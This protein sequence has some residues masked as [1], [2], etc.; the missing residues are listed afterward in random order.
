MYWANFLHIYQPPTQKE[1]WVRRITKES[2]RK[3]FSGFLNIPKCRLTLNINSVLCEL[4]EKWGGEDVIRDI[5]ELLKRGKLEL[6]GSAKYHA[7]LPLIPENEIRRQIKLNE[8]GLDKYFGGYWQKN[9]FFSPEMAYSNKVAEIAKEMGYKWMIID[10]MGFPKSVKYAP[11]KLY[12]I[13]G[14]DNF[15]VFFRERNL[16]FI[17]LSAQ[18]GT[19][20]A[21]LRYLGDRLK[22][23]EYALTAMDGETFGHH[24]P[25]ME[26]FLFDLLSSGEV[27]SVAVGDLP[28]LFPDRQTIEPQ[29]S[30]W[31]VTEEDMARNEPYARWKR[32]DNEIQQNQWELT[33]LA[34]EVAGRTPEN[35][36]LCSALD[37]ALHSDQYW[38]ASARPW[39]SLEMIERG[40]YELKRIILDS[41]AAKDEEKIRAEDYYKNILY[42]GFAWQ[43]EG[44]VDEI[45]RQEDEDVLGRLHQKGKLFITKEEY[46]KMIETLKGQ[47]KSAV[48]DEDY[49]RAA[50]L[51]DRIQELAEEMEKANSE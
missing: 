44:K 41:P 49:N 20:S 40:A 39:W 32:E 13:K 4:L 15:G 33:D 26:Q 9:G 22:K 29:P 38:W 35:Y 42:T 34:I 43:R 17:V 5:K 27:R 36:I 45:A 24:R 1:I 51:K 11:D 37:R 12:Q 8:E 10:E 19:M 14:V 31:A 23:N 50:M 7:F 28:D 25:G 6:T 46:N 3:I 47:I 16:S 48:K 30:T 18:I 2:Y 21:I